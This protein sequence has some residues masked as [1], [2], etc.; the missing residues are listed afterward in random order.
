MQYKGL[1][2]S[3]VFLLNS[4]VLTCY[5]V[6]S[7]CLIR[8]LISQMTKLFFKI[9]GKYPVICVLL[10]TSASFGFKHACYLSSALHLRILIIIPRQGQFQL[11]YSLHHNKQQKI[12][13]R[14][15]MNLWLSKYYIVG[16]QFTSLTVHLAS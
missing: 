13:R 16:I 4:S 1:Y 15:M 10:K 11:H 3:E 7:I 9:I 5:L 12:K 6:T 2:N 8:H 14:G